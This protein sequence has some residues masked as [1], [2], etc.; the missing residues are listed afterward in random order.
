[1]I[2]KEELIPNAKDWVYKVAKNH[3]AL[4]E[5]GTLR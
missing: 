5:C 1:M 4:Q 2:Q 3:E